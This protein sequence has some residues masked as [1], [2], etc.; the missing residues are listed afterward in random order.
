MV[1]TALHTRG[2]ILYMCITHK[3][4]WWTTCLLFLVLSR[5]HTRTH[6]QGAK[7][8]IIQH[9]STHV[10]GP[11]LKQG[12]EEWWECKQIP[13]QRSLF[14]GCMCSPEGAVQRWKLY[15]KCNSTQ[16]IK[17]IIFKHLLWNC[18]AATH[19]PVFHLQTCAK[20]LT[21][22]ESYLIASWV[23]ECVYSIHKMTQL[24]RILSAVPLCWRRTGFAQQ[25]S[26]QC[27]KVRI[28]QRTNSDMFFR[29]VVLTQ[30]CLCSTSPSDLVSHLLASAQPWL[31]QKEPQPTFS[32]TSQPWKIMN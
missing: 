30:R 15:C 14:L 22:R 17:S 5:T 18:P 20:L 7:Y 9:I 32:R 6:T 3:C 2:Q 21:L 8:T 16:Y 26:R 31:D 11:S 27:V 25:K 1:P 12:D 28:R 24:E 29:P 23:A 13:R 19:S 4:T 10:R